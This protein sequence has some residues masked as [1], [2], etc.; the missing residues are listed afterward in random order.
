MWLAHEFRMYILRSAAESM[1]NTPSK[2]PAGG[3]SSK[4]VGGK[5]GGSKEEIEDISA[6]VSEL[7]GYA[8]ERA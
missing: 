7:N 3:R 4:Y 8:G 6:G 5:G 2:I 1:E